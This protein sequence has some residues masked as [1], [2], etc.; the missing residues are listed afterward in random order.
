MAGQLHPYTGGTKKSTGQKEISC[1]PCLT[2]TIGEQGV[3]S[4]LS[5]F[6][7]CVNLQ[8]VAFP[9]LGCRGQRRVVK[10]G[11]LKEADSSE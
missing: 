3:M 2:L 10:S 4:I 8:H 5:G 6:E 11:G 7:Y 9:V 1:P